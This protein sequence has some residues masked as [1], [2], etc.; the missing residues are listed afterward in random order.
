MKTK[1]KFGLFLYTMLIFFVATGITVSLWND[2][3]NS[4]VVQAA[5]LG[6]GCNLASDCHGIPCA[7]P[8][9][10]YCNVE[11]PS[12]PTGYA[13]VCE[14]V[15]WDQQR[16]NGCNGVFSPTEPPACPA[17]WEDCGTSYTN[18]SSAI[19]DGCQITSEIMS[20][21]ENCG[22]TSVIYRFCR[23]PQT[24][25][26]PPKE[27]EPFCGDTI[28]DAGEYCERTRNNPDA[29][30]ECLT[31]GDYPRGRAVANCRNIQTAPGNTSPNQCTFCGD[32]VRQPS[33]ECDYAVDENCNL[34]CTYQELEEGIRIDKTVIEDRLYQVGEQIRFHV[35]IT[36]TGE[37]T[38]DVVRFRDTWDPTYLS[39]IG[40]S[41]RN[42]SGDTISDINPIL[43]Y[44]TNNQ[45]RIADVTAH[46]GNLA[47]N[48]YY[49]FTLV[50][51]AIAPTPQYN[52][53]TCNNAFVRG[54]DLPET[55]D[56][57]C[58]P[59]GNRDTDI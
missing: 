37:S 47:P 5:E 19:P 15:Q 12:A 43:T 30:R 4:S 57:D 25:P 44:R 20:T 53:E 58:I 16:I 36:N 13:G 35:R 29:F 32:G 23:Q 46:L 17:G 31:V 34:N 3:S 1:L 48:Q 45:I 54:D 21:C 6:E 59:I 10:S 52:P 38:F 27:P 40:G 39:Y 2:G 8:L 18:N 56:D 14:C 9:N 49:E 28:C 7:Y 55:R 50:F 41:V 51:T 24:P 22:N 26:P 33:E 42:S 11:N